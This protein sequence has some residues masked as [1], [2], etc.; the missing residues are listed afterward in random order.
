MKLTRWAPR[1]DALDLKNEMDNIFRDFFEGYPQTRES[2]WAPQ[3]DIHEDENSYV[4]TADLPGVKKEDIKLTTHNNTLSISGNKAIER[5]DKEK[6]YHR[7]ERFSGTYERS[8][9]LPTTADLEKVE[10]KYKD[11]VLEILVPKK[12]ESKKKEIEVKID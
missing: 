9:Q 12:E 2:N 8:F 6:N 4:F 5:E 7:I 3:V 1:R 11:G 10:A